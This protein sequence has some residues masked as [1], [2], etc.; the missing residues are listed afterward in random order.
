M[1]MVRPFWTVV[2]T[3]EQFGIGHKKVW[4]AVFKNIKLKHLGLS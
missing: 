2:T 3:V 1:L 4:I